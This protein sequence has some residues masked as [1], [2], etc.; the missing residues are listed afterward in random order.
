MCFYNNLRGSLRIYP[1]DAQR[2]IH[3]T[4]S[5]KLIAPITFDGKPSPVIPRS[6]TLAS[7]ALMPRSGLLTFSFA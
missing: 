4:P 7:A 3:R 6:P 5:A 2:V 1:L